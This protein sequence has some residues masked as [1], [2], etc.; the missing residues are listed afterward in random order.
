MRAGPWRRLSTEELMLFLLWCWRRNLRAPWTARRS[1]QS[2]LKEINLKYS[3]EGLMQKLKYFGHLTWRANSLEKTLMLGK[4]EGIRRRGWQKMRWFDGITDSMDMSLN[5]LWE[6]VKDRAAWWA[7]VYGITKSQTQLSG[8]TAPKMEAGSKEELKILF[9]M[10]KDGS[11][12]S[13]LKLNVQEH[14]IQSH[15]FMANRW[16]KSRNSGR[17]YFLGLQNHCGWSLQPWS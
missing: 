10:M 3:L 9:M 12:E 5:K 11:E 4:I 6:M 15:H 2:I 14:G 16:G 17:F 13:S 8:W 7:S 1:N